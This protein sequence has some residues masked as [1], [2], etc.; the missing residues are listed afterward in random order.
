[1]HFLKT[2]NIIRHFVL[3]LLFAMIVLSLSWTMFKL[4]PSLGYGI[5]LIVYIMIIG[6]QI[7][8]YN[9]M[10]YFSFSKSLLHFILNFILWCVEQVLV[11]T[12]F[13][14]SFLYQDE[15]YKFLII[16]LGAILWATNKLLLDILFRMVKLK[17]TELNKLDLWLANKLSS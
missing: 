9:L 5:L 15:N 14:K 2:S 10:T 17:A 8:F 13:E 16:I 7:Y 6:A 11:S 3:S 12:N 4:F 1:M